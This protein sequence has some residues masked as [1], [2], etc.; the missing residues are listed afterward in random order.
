MSLCTQDALCGTT[1]C[2]SSKKMRRLHDTNPHHP[3]PCVHL[4]GQHSAWPMMAVQWT[5]LP[6]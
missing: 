5:R 1:K 2:T 6:K 3:K 4:Q